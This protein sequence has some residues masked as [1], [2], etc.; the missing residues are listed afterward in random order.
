MCSPR[1]EDRL[2]ALEALAFDDYVSVNLGAKP[3]IF[4][5]AITHYDPCAGSTPDLVAFLVSPAL[6]GFAGAVHVLAAAGYVAVTSS[7]MAPGPETVDEARALKE[8][9]YWVTKAFVRGSSCLVKKGVSEIATQ[10]K[11]E[12]D[13]GRALTFVELMWEEDEEYLVKMLGKIEKGGDSYWE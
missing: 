2:P 8:I 5:T 6:Y 1:S 7:T 9:T 4:T 10:Q 3:V 12:K 11:V 13:F